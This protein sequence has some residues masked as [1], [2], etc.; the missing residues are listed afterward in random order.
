[1]ISAG[2]EPIGELRVGE[3]GVKEVLLG[4]NAVYTRQGGYFYLELNTKET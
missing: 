1:M 3:M 2:S 4:E